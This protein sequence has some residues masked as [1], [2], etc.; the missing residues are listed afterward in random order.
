MGVPVGRL[1]WGCTGSRHHLHVQNPQIIREKLYSFK[2]VLRPPPH[3]LVCHGR[4]RLRLV[5]LPNTQAAHLLCCTGESGARLGSSLHLR[6]RSWKPLQGVTAMASPG[7][8]TLGYPQKLK[9]ESNLKG[10]FVLP[11][12]PLCM[13]EQAAELSIHNF[14][15]PETKG[16]GQI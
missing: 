16:V 3:L 12:H 7:E 14:K 10:S 15:H 2:V 6:H 13:R 11:L 4:L 1:S 8:P 9:V 5:A